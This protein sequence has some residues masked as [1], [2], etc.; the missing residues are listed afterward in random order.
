MRPVRARRLP[1]PASASP[2][3]GKTSRIGNPAALRPRPSDPAERGFSSARD[4]TVSVKHV[5]LL[6]LLFITLPSINDAHENVWDSWTRDLQRQ[7]PSNHVDWIGDDFHDEL[8]TAF[9]QTLP[10]SSQRRVSSLADY[11]RRC[12]GVKIGSSCE[13]SVHLD[14]FIRLG[15]LK[16]F[17]AFGCH[18]YKCEEPALCTQL[19]R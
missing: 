15:L 14:A 6:L 19:A 7:C 4:N 3:S 8:L 12:A 5:R 13:M 17:T 10:P 9:V 11:S 16:R 2:A 18:R 1:L